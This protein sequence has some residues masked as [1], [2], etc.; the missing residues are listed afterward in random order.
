MVTDYD[1]WKV[2]EEPVTSITEDG[3]SSDEPSDEIGRLGS[4]LFDD[5]GWTDVLDAA[6]FTPRVSS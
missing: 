6:E 4:T 2:E 1:C 5:D 3:S